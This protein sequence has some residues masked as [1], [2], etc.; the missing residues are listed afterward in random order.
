M[1][2]VAVFLTMVAGVSSS[3]ASIISIS[4]A[5]AIVAAPLSVE[6]GALESDLHVFTFA[7]QRNHLLTSDLRV[8][9]TAPGLYDDRSDLPF[10]V[11]TLAAGTRVD[12]YFLHADPATRG[13]SYVGSITFDTDVLAVLLGGMLLDESDAFL[14]S[15]GTSYPADPFTSARGLA[16]SGQDTIALSSDRRTLSVMYTTRQAIDQVRVVTAAQEVPEPAALALLGSGL[17]MMRIRQRR[18][19]R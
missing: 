18:H 12:S 5:V 11:P 2:A 4:G 8:N 14:G 9:F 1:T 15:P 10:P 6:E 19:R 13:V 17:A 7:E 16:L 3:Q